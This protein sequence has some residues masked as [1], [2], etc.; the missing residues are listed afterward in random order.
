MQGKEIEEI[1]KEVNMQTN[2]DEKIVSL[3][4]LYRLQTRFQNEICNKIGYNGEKIMELPVDK[5]D[6]FQCQC[7]MLLE[8]IGELVKSDKR[9]KNFRNEKYDKTNKLEEIADCFI[10]LFNIC[11]FSDFDCSEVEQAI[12]DKMIGNFARIYKEKCDKNE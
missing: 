2:L 5:P 12:M 8:E 1:L 6:I 11:L 10:V 4:F 3:N 7:L 9:W